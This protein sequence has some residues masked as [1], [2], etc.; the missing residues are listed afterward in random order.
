MELGRGG[1]ASGELSEEEGRDFAAN[2][3]RWHGALVGGAAVGLGAA[4]VALGAGAAMAQSSSDVQMLQTA[5]SIE[6]LAIATYSLAAPPSP[7]SA[8]PARTGSSRPS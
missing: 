7:S 5:Q 8:A 6:N 3:D 2:R 1:R 4:V